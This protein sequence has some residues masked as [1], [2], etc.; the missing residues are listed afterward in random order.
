MSKPIKSYPRWE[1]QEVIAR[2]LKEEKGGLGYWSAR[3][4]EK[5]LSGNGK[6]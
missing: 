5:K 3:D 1:R 6:Q 2:R 4:A